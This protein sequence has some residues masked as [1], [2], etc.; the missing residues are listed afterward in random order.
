MNLD[1]LFLKGQGSGMFVPA[2]KANFVRI[3][4]G[5]GHKTMGNMEI[6]GRFSMTGNDFDRLQCA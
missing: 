1:F 3:L 2:K 4:V 6:P 5:N